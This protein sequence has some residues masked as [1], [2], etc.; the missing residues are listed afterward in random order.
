MVSWN[1]EVAIDI[2]VLCSLLCVVGT[3]FNGIIVSNLS[4]LKW[5]IP[6]VWFW[7]LMFVCVFRF[8]STWKKQNCEISSFVSWDS[9]THKRSKIVKF[10]IFFFSCFEILKHTRETRLCFVML[11]TWILT[12]YKWVFLKHKKHDDTRPCVHH[13]PPLWWNA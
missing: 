8:W 5:F 10:Q 6:S 13:L 9:K 11:W 2:I 3:Q 7:S 4:C 1:L 12:C